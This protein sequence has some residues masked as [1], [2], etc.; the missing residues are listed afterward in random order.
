MFDSH[1][2]QV[3]IDRIQD[4]DN[5]A[6]DALCKRYMARVY[7]AVRIR[8]GT[9]LRAKLQSCD[10]VQ[11]VMLDVLKGA[12]NFECRNEGAFLNWINCAVENKI[13]D[14]ADHWHA[15]KRHQDR[16]VP[17]EKRR[18]SR[19]A[20]PLDLPENDSVLT[21]SAIVV[22]QEELKLLETAMD[23]LLDISE[24]Y[25]RIIIATKIEGQTYA[26]I[27]EVEGKSVDAVRMQVNRAQ[28]ELA[29]IFRKLDQT[30]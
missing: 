10:V 13:R 5:M 20:F 1:A 25:H 4:G 23:A 8:L 19:G 26:E 30:D 12:Q 17:I 27:A 29:K 22:K 21:P 2:T 24:D 9:K 7:S 28:V 15:K 11:D 16:E 18:S 3:L 14:K 6:Y